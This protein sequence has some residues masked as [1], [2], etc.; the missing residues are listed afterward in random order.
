MTAATL[1]ATPGRVSLPGT[2][3]YPDGMEFLDDPANLPRFT[4]G[5]RRGQVNTDAIPGDALIGTKVWAA[6]QGVAFETVQKQRAVAARRR[7][8]GA[9]KA[10]D[11][12]VEDHKVGQ[13]PLWYMATYRAW[14]PTRP[15]RGA[16]AG[17]PRTGRVKRI[18]MARLPITVTCPHGEVITITAADVRE[19]RVQT[20]DHREREEA[21]TSASEE[22]R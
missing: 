14:V 10:G 18:R 13:S 8:D 4:R 9:V 15:G 12:P 22:G 2:G 11:M 21:R 19:G 5:K 16:G 17:R 6:L 20:G 3:L 1:D 7:R